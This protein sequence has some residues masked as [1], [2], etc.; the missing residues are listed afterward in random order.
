[1]RSVV[2]STGEAVEA[3]AREKNAK[4]NWMKNGQYL[5]T[6]NYFLQRASDDFR[7]I[8]FTF[9][10]KCV[11]HIKDESLTF[12]MPVNKGRAF[13]KCQKQEEFRAVAA[14]S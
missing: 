2:I 5:F 12:E 14:C 9:I 11:L 8:I 7:K 1:V 6:R 3:I 4:S 13:H 10:G